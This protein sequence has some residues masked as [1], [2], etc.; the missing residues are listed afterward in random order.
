MAWLEVSDEPGRES[1]RGVVERTSIALLSCCND[2]Q[3]DA[4][5]DLWLGHQSTSDQVQ[6]SGL[7]NQ[8]HVKEQVDPGKKEEL[9]D[10][11]A[12]QIHG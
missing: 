4:P 7:W 9:F 12:K 11:I 5:T 6:Q 3:A 10:L 2:T 1:K 8:K